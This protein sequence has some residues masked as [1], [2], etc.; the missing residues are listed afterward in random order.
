MSK[1]KKQTRRQYK[2]EEEDTEL[3][4]GEEADSSEKD[5]SHS[6]YRLQAQLIRQDGGFQWP[7]TRAD[8][9]PRTEPGCTKSIPEARRER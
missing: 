1:K 7:W 9:M 8:E 2:L 3:L 4:D 5:S 6:L